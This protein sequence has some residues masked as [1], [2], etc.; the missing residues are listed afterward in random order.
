[1]EQ[2]MNFLQHA[3]KAFLLCLGCNGITS[4]LLWHA[5]LDAGSYTAITIATTGAYIGAWATARIKG[6]PADRA[7]QP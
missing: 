4:L 2:Q 3:D 7:P 1:M 5:K 6:T